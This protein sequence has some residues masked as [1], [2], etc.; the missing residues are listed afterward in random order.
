MLRG[1]RPPEGQEGVVLVGGVA[2]DALDA[3]E[4][5]GQGGGGGGALPGPGP[6]QRDPFIV[7]V[8]QVQA[9]AHGPLEHE[10]LRALVHDPRAAGENAASGEYGII[11][12][13][14]RPGDP[15]PEPQHQRGRLLR[16]F[17]V[18]RRQI[19]EPRLAGEDL[20]GIIRERRQPA[21]VFLQQADRALPVVGAAVAGILQPHA[22]L[23]DG[24]V[25][26]PERHAERHGLAPQVRKG[27]PVV[28]PLAAVELPGK[29]ARQYGDDVTQRVVLQMKGQR[30]FVDKDL[31]HGGAPFYA[32]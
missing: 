25:R 18:G 30:G 19:F 11:Q 6:V 1:V 9:Q 28:D 16:R 3:L 21:A 32:F 12:L 20:V 24:T 2:A 15:V 22:L 13:A 7:V 31:L 8:R 29:P 4:A 10:R 26:Q 17:D 23:G 5:R 14:Q 27:R